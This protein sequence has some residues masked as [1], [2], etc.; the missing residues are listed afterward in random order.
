MINAAVE[1]FGFNETDLKN[2]RIFNKTSI[3]K[4]YKNLAK[5]YHCDRKK[6]QTKE[7]LQLTSDLGILQTLCSLLFAATTFKTAIDAF[8]QLYKNR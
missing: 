3:N 6:G 4:R 1:T 7:F 8:A 2:R 5:K